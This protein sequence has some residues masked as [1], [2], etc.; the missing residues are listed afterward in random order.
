[1]DTKRDGSIDLLRFIAIFLMIFAHANMIL[2]I[3]N[4]SIN[5]WIE[6]A[7]NTICFSLF[8]F[9]YGAS[10]YKSIEKYPTVS[11][12]RFLKRIGLM[13]LSY[14]IIAVLTLIET[15]SLDF[16][17]F[18][19]FAFFITRAPYAEFLI[20]FILFEFITLLFKKP[21]ITISSKLL[22]LI[23][24]SIFFFFLG[25]FLSK[26]LSLGELDFIGRLIYGADN[27][28]SFPV[29]QYIPFLF[30]GIYYSMKNFALKT[31]LTQGL[32][33][34]SVS[35]LGLIASVYLKQ[36]IA[37]NR[38]TPSLTFILIGV[39]AIG[40]CISL[41]IFKRPFIEKKVFSNFLALINKYT[42]HI[43]YSH[44]ILLYVLRWLKVGV[45]T[46]TPYIVLL[47]IAL[48]FYLLVYA[49]KKAKTASPDY[50]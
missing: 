48:F 21:V 34:V 39:F 14:I 28:Y 29:L 13:Y 10:W 5:H 41:Y 19:S 32:V 4:Y 12:P 18:L 30:A 35:T 15:S 31:R 8:L 50:S 6:T 33:L 7:G 2:N 38:W 20:A 27:K 36:F 24:A 23:P 1:M 17:S 47:I 16:T 11:L 3:Q 42:I 25:D 43:L 44:L 45:S 40:I 49:R 22:F 46:L 26:N 37:F 9:C